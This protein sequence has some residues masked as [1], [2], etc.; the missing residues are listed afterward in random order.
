METTVKIGDNA[1]LLSWD[2]NQT[3]PI[4]EIVRAAEELGGSEELKTAWIV[5]ADEGDS[6]FLVLSTVEV[7]WPDAYELCRQLLS[8]V[9]CPEINAY[10]ITT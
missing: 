4:A 7:T 9:Q 10:V 1:R 2:M 3:V 6:M 5:F 8:G